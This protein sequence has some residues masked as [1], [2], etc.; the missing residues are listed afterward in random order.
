MWLSKTKSNDFLIAT[1]L[2]YCSY[3]FI[4]I[5]I[6]WMIKRAGKK[7]GRK[8]LST[9]VLA[10]VWMI[11]YDASSWFLFLF[12]A[13]ILWHVVPERESKQKENIDKKN[14]F[15]KLTDNDDRW[16]VLSWRYQHIKIIDKRSACIKLRDLQ[17]EYA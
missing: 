10:I 7:W 2:I 16:E 5:V 17:I 1:H 12:S 11:T 4:V 14:F 15:F 3:V 9:L 6:I 13:L 8:F